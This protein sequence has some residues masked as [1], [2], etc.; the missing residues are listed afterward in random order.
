MCHKAALEYRRNATLFSA[1]HTGHVADM[2]VALSNIFPIYGHFF[3]T[4]R[5]CEKRSRAY[6][7]AQTRDIARFF[8]SEMPTWTR[9]T[10]RG[11]QG[12]GR[13]LYCR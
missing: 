5:H 4:S 11:C 13:V 3:H 8:E 1:L 7:V 2:H 10:S 12:L 9:R 6:R